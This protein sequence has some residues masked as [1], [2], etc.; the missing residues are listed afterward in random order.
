MSLTK[1]IASSKPT[2][3]GCLPA[4]GRA[5]G[6]FEEMRLADVTFEGDALVAHF[7]DDR[8]ISVDL[9][10]YPRL[11]RATPLQRKKCRL[12]GKG[13]GIHWEKL[14]EDL[15]VDNLSFANAKAAH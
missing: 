13:L 10:R 8:K 11:L 14:D 7:A 15:S 6:I 9:N 4:G 2:T 1:F 3:N 5:S 12:I